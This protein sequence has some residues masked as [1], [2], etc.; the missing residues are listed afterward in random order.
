MTQYA[1]LSLK[2]CKFTYF[3]ADYEALINVETNNM[4]LVPGV[5]VPNIVRQLG[6]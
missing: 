5:G 4:A 2:N 1:T 6:D 3:L